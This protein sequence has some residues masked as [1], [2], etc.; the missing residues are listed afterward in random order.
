L[1][2]LTSKFD[3]LTIENKTE[4]TFEK[5][6]PSESAPL[7]VTFNRTTDDAETVTFDQI[8][9]FFGNNVTCPIE[10][11]SLHQ[12]IRDV[13]L[14]TTLARIVRIDPTSNLITIDNSVEESQTIDFVLK[15]KTAANAFG[16][17]DV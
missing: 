1:D 15:V 3:N 16:Y 8:K 4:C 12:D 7:V 6:S 9:A 5:L 2:N 13:R 14:S 11:V 10:S 17:K